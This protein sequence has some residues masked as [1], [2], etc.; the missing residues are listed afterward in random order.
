MVHVTVAFFIIFN[1]AF[2]FGRKSLLLRKQRLDMLGKDTG[3]K[4]CSEGFYVQM[5]LN[6]SPTADHTLE[7]E[8]EGGRACCR[9][10]VE[11]QGSLLGINGERENV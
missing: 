3:H 2:Y 5:S 9:N 10:K 7:Y 11:R 4:K 1:T 6:S 8:G